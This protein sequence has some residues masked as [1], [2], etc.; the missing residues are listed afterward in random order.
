MKK[1]AIV[2]ICLGLVITFSSQVMAKDGKTKCATIKDGTIE[3]GR[4]G[5]PTTEIIHIG[6][7]QWGYNYQAHMF[8]G[9]YDN[10]SRPDTLADEGNWLQ[11]KWSDE[12]LS[13]K[14][15]NGDGKLDR[16]YSCDS[17]S[18]S[19]SN[20]P[21]AWLTNHERGTYINDDEEECNYT[22]FVKIVAAPA[23]AY[24]NEGFWYTD[25][26]DEEIGPVIWGAYAIIQE[27]SNDSCAG[28][29]GILYKSPA[30]PGFG[31]Y[32]PE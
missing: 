13:N 12:W 28:E 9:Y 11:M 6:Y 23:D 10:Y 22:Y 32:H 27:V 31:Q 18:A 24:K 30:G 1:L 19:S 17:E 25:D 2:L 20:C 5:D 21:G 16:G 8:N 15:C 3:Y 14:D 29:H 26:D 4:V 7:D